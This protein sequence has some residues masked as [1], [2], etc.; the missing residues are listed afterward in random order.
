MNG[1][2]KKVHVDAQG[3]VVLSGESVIEVVPLDDS[4]LVQANVRPEDIGFVHSDQ[5][6]MVKFTAYDY[7]RYGGME[8]TVEYIGADTITNESG[9]TYYPIRIRT[10]SNT[11]G[12]K[13]GRDLSIIPGM[14]T[15][16]DLLAG[17]KTVLQYLLTPINRAREKALKER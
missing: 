10:K 13:D 16:V 7:I 1:V 2:V 12:T 5:Q 3:Q 9:E 6:A 8:G 11:M 15:D 17:K 4:L 14:V